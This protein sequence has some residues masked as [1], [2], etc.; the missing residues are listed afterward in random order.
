MPS[1]AL[2]LTARFGVRQAGAALAH[3]ARP[4][5]FYGARHA[6]L[7]DAS[8]RGPMARALMLEA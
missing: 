4:A 8:S 5:A 2:L 1:D 7:C 6:V 3:V